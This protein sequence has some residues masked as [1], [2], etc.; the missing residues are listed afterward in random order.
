MT[1]N[2]AEMTGT[3]GMAV[4]CGLSVAAVW[5]ISAG[6]FLDGVGTRYYSVKVQNPTF[7]STAIGAQICTAT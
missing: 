7:T 2:L 5:T 1:A 3:Q 6:G 4:L